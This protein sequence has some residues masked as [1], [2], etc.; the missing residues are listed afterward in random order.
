MCE[1]LHKFPPPPP[2]LTPPLVESSRNNMQKLIPSIPH[3]QPELREHEIELF[4]VEE[5]FHVSIK[6]RQQQ[7]STAQQTNNLITFQ[8]INLLRFS[9]LFAV[10]TFK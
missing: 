9:L 8:S 5:A 2:H 1:R 6:C 10:L 4:E 3:R 7:L